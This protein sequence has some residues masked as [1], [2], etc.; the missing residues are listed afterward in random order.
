MKRDC[1]EFDGALD[2]ARPCVFRYKPVAAV[3]GCVV[4]HLFQRKLKLKML[5]YNNLQCHAAS[6]PPHIL[7]IFGLGAFGIL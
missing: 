1:F 5:K 2:P 3:A 7:I 4:G 6:G